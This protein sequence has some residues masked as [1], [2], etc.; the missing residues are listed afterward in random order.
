MNQE[1][2]EF[3]KLMVLTSLVAPLGDY[4]LDLSQK[5]FQNC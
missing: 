3:L 2:F 4:F 5:K 1:L